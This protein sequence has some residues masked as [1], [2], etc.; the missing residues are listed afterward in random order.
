MASGLDKWL[1]HTCCPDLL[2]RPLPQGSASENSATGGGPPCPAPRMATAKKMRPVPE[3][4][5]GGDQTILAVRAGRVGAETLAAVATAS[6]VSPFRP[7]KLRL[8]TFH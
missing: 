1:P 7:V 5:P 4:Q 6:A 3:A 2:R 8:P